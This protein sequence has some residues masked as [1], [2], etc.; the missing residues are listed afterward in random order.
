MKGI[1]MRGLTT[2]SWAGWTGT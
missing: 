2:N 1:L